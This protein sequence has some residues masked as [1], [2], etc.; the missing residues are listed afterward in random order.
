MLNGRENVLHHGSQSSTFQIIDTVE[1]SLSN[2]I[3]NET[4]AFIT[5]VLAQE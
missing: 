3:S 2:Q 1:L 4:R 5:L